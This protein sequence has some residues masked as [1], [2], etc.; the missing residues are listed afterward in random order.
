MTII[1]VK[2]RDAILNSFYPRG[3]ENGC[4][5]FIFYTRVVLKKKN[6]ENAEKTRPPQ[7]PSPRSRGPYRYTYIYI[8]IIIISHRRPTRKYAVAKRDNLSTEVEKK[9][10]T[11]YAGII[12]LFYRVQRR[13]ARRKYFVY[14]SRTLCRGTRL[15]KRLHN[16][17]DNPTLRPPTCVP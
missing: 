7:L 3:I 12:I 1:V 16:R 5:F 9:T 15:V 13:L 10:R 4:M 6:F 17:K 11:A 8:F 14:R 2:T